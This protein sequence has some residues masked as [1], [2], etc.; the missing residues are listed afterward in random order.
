[1]ALDQVDVDKIGQAEKEMS[2]LDHLEELRWHLFRSVAALVI[3][4]IVVFI[5]GD[6]FFENIIFAPTKP[7]FPTY[8]FLCSF[9]D[10]LCMIP[11]KLVFISVAFGEEFIVHLKV[12]LQMGLVIAFPYF[13]WEVWRFVKPGLYEKEQKVT[14]G[15]VGISSFLFMSGVLFGFFVIAPFAITFLGSYDIGA[16]NSPSI[17]SYVSYLTMFTIPTGIVFQLPLVIYFLSKLGV[18]TPDFLRTYRRHAIVVILILSALITPPDAI[19]QLL[20][21]VPLFGLYEISIRISARVYKKRQ[22]E[23]AAEN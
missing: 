3:G 2:F 10:F 20:I 4:A 18:V 13:F 19:T 16:T 1:M 6:W 7:E 12:S 8:R 5:S 15:V 22:K 9:G 17:S 14:R 21:G 23:L 11:P